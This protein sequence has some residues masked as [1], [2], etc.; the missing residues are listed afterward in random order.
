[1][2]NEEFQNNNEINENEEETEE[3]P[4]CKGRSC[5]AYEAAP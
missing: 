3:L 2:E 5:K 4:L 1:M